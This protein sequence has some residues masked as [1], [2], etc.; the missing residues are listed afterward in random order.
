MG[1]KRLLIKISSLVVIRNSRPCCA[2]QRGGVHG[3]NDRTVSRR[4]VELRLDGSQVYVIGLGA[5][6]LLR[7]RSGEVSELVRGVPELFGP[8]DT[9][10]YGEGLSLR[11]VPESTIAGRQDI[12]EG[13]VEEPSDFELDK[14]IEPFGPFE[15]DQGVLV[16]ASG[17]SREPGKRYMGKVAVGLVFA[18]ISLVL[19]FLSSDNWNWPDNWN[20]LEDSPNVIATMTTTTV[21]ETTQAPEPVPETTQAPEPV[22]E[23]GCRTRA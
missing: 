17:P 23:P 22:P 13:R 8:G 2:H 19:V 7:R 4:H 12:D 14:T 6:T 11:Y 16:T 3:A 5:Q 21:P 15:E 10:H 1:L 9:L 20:W 18:M